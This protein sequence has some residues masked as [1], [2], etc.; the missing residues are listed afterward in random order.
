MYEKPSEIISKTKKKI[1]KDDISKTTLK[2]MQ[3]AEKHLSY[4]TYSAFLNDASILMS[5]TIDMWSRP[6]INSLFTN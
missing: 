5:D 3:S 4:K 6:E 2:T 1:E